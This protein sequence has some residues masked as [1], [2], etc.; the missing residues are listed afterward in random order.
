MLFFTLIFCGA[1]EGEAGFIG[2]GIFHSKSCVGRALNCF[3]GCVEF[4]FSLGNE[5]CLG[6]PSAAIL[7]LLCVDR[8]RGPF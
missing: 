2:E 1:T 7:L 4:D 6:L 5:R 3:C 8:W